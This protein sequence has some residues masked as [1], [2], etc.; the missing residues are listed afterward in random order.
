MWLHILNTIY[1]R[2]LVEVMWNY[3]INS[4]GWV[5]GSSTKQAKANIKS[6][7]RQ[8]GT[9]PRTVP[10][11]IGDAVMDVLLDWEP[12]EDILHVHSDVAKPR[13]T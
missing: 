13:D 7:Q 2:P 1:G 3:K 5:E 4:E 8:T 10:N 9:L 6:Y 12:V 11:S